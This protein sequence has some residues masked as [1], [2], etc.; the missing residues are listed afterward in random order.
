MKSTEADFLSL[1]RLGINREAKPILQD[2][3]WEIVLN[4]AAQHGLSGVLFDGIERLPEY[5]RPS[6]DVLLQW[7]GTTLESESVQ[8]MQQKAAEEMARLFHKNGIRTYVLKGDVIAEC[9]PKPLHRVSSDMDCY[10]MMEKDSTEDSH[11]KA[12]KLGNDLIRAAGYLIDDDYYKNSG[13]ELPGLI[14]ENHQYMTPFRGNKRLRSLELVLQ[15]MMKADKGE[16]VFEGSYLYRPPVMASALFMIEH[17]YSHFLHEGLTW[18]MILD[19][20]LFGEKHHSEIDW[21]SLIAMIDEFGLRKFYDSYKRLG[22]YLIGEVAEIDLSDADRMMLSDVWA[23]LDLH[24]N[25]YGL[26]AKI[27]LAGNTWRARWKYKHFAEISWIE[28]LWIQVKGFLF[29]RHPKI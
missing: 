15:S 8:A 1:L 20:K 5:L 4:I 11:Q 3:E 18:R 7:I 2:V 6:K 17:A 14:V 26:K 28:A 16:N 9:Y 29:I 13:F 23:P 19:W 10:L 24:E 27:N 22:K 25:L 12:W 21:D